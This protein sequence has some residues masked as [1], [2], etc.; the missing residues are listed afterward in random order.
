MFD[1]ASKQRVRLALFVGFLIGASIIACTSLAM[2]S[3]W[4]FAA[5][6]YYLHLNIEHSGESSA[7]N[8]PEKEVKEDKG[9]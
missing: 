4:L 1:E 5:A 9:E 7:V 8:E 2:F 6:L 3:G